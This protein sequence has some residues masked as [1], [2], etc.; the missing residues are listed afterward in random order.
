MSELHTTN[1]AQTEPVT[2]IVNIAAYKFT[3][4]DELAQRRE[5]LR[6]S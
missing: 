1:V 5:A 4:L 3:P 6:W 2:P